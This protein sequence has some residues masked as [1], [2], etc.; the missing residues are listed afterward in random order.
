MQY[1]SL[2]KLARLA[3]VLYKPVS[4]ESVEDTFDDLIVYATIWKCDYMSRQNGK[5]ISDLHTIRETKD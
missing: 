4:N 1:S 3:T 5:P 2:L